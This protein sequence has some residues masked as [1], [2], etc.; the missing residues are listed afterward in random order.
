MELDVRGQRCPVPYVRARAL[1]DRLAPGETLTVLFT[2]PEAP[3]DLGALA[4]ERGF[5]FAV[6]GEAIRLRRPPRPGADP[7]LR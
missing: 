4:A 7:P 5:E 3:I 1:V 2:D 6:A